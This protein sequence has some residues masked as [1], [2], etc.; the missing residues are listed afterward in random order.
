MDD[1]SA[2][3]S[4]ERMVSDRIVTLSMPCWSPD[5]RSIAAYT[6]PIPPGG[7]SYGP[8][9]WP[10]QVYTQFPLDGGTPLDMAVG[11]VESVGACAWQRLA[12]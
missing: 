5:D 8:S 11:T 3:G 1:G 10:N 12:P 9:G 6:G 2:D 4:G 7:E